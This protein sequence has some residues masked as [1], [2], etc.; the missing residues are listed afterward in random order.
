MGGLVEI[1]RVCGGLFPIQR[2]LERSI[3][4]VLVVLLRTNA[5]LLWLLSGETMVVIR[6]LR[7]KSGSP[8]RRCQL[9]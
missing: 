2:I 4:V 1:K 6:I 5:T 7:E 3:L 8:W 9:S